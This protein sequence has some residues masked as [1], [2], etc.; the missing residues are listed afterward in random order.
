[1]P[2]TAHYPPPPRSLAAAGL[3]PRVRRTLERAL[4]FVSNEL[5][6]GLSSLV[7]E[8]EQELFRLADHARNPGLESGYMATLRAFRAN[9]ADLLPRFLLALEGSIAA[10]RTPAPPPPPTPLDTAS[11]G[12]LSLVEDTVM[13]EGTVLREIASR[14]E[15]R[16]NL[17]L[18]LLG[19]RFGVLAASPAFDAERLPLGPQCLCRAIASAAR[20][21]EIEHDARLL[22]YRIFDR[23]VMPGYAR[24]LER[25]DAQLADDGILPSLTFVPM[26]ARA[27]AVEPKEASRVARTAETVEMPRPQVDD[28]Q[29]PYTGWGEPETVDDDEADDAQSHEAAYARLQALMSGRRELLRKFQPRTDSPLP[30]RQLATSEVSDAL[31]Q[32][33]QQPQGG[34][35]TLVEIKR[36]LLAQAR[37][38]SGEGAMLAPQDED[39]FE[40]LGML[41]GHIEQEIRSEA[42]AAP[43]VRE[44]QIPVLRAALQ[45][46]SFFTRQRHPARQLLNTVAESA[47]NWH[48]DTAFDP[49][50]Q[51][52]LRAAVAFVVGNYEGDVAV[53]AEG[54]AR[55]Q[56]QLQTQARTAE[57]QERRHI[58]AARGREKL[59]AARARADELMQGIVGDRRL[60]RFSRALLDQAWADVLTLTLLRHGESSSEA[61]HQLRMT[62]RI[63]EASLDA[64]PRAD[65]ALQSDVESALG[66]VGYHG[67]EATVI[68]QRLTSHRSDE[69]DAASRTEL[70]MK[71]KAR[72]RLGEEA[73]A[74]RREKPPVRTAE[75]Q[76]QYDHLR[77]LPFGTWIEFT[78]NQQGD[79]VRRRMSWYSP[80][81]DHVLF[82]N[83]RGQRTGEQ[84][85]DAVAR[86][87]ATGNARVVTADRGHLVDRAWQAAMGALRSF[88]GRGESRTS[89]VTA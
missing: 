30:R 78:T 11:F 7:S 51:A 8:F 38:R 52:A 5:D 43:L 14:Q 6:G 27:E 20:M 59:A 23:V 89:E 72:A 39:A 74:A 62:R 50:V 85:M 33:Q 17:S 84:S 2:A 68:A 66:Q 21:L 16:A 47:A 19:Q 56:A 54:N 86:L 58:E 24:V 67:E 44:L 64:V 34:G 32:L 13:D 63:V 45:D 40:L 77:T 53:F 25:L 88:A 46:H 79:M 69:D 31:R 75:E 57:L 70:A 87:M 42:P 26:R 15:G 80:I 71:L 36:S 60:P 10:I 76:A 3:P 4:S 55:V 61:E 82:V 49:R 35:R 81:T 65:E 83:Q 22:L 18:H 9:R 48:D 28:A 29:R 41:Y 12:P 73:G 37:Q 1:M